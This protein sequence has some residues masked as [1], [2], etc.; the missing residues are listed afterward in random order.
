MGATGAGAGPSNVVRVAPNLDVAVLRREQASAA[1]GATPE[2][3]KVPASDSR[4]TGRLSLAKVPL[5]FAAVCAPP[6]PV[7][8]TPP[9]SEGEPRLVDFDENQSDFALA[10][11][12]PTPQVAT[13]PKDWPRA[14]K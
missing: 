14:C 11:G 9:K 10:D 6:A 5:E 7:A 1:N 4:A 12:T 8:Q 2:P 3:T 13:V